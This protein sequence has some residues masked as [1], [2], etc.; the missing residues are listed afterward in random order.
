LLRTLVLTRIASRPCLSVCRYDT[1]SQTW[2]RSPAVGPERRHSAVMMTTGWAHLVVWGG[3]S[4]LYGTVL[5]DVS[6]FDFKAGAWALDMDATRVVPSMINRRPLPRYGHAV[7]RSGNV[8]YE[9][10]GVL[11]GGQHSNKLHI[12]R[13]AA[14]LPGS[15]TPG[16]GSYVWSQV[17]F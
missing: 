10:G 16:A 2:F 1:W 3:V 12:H 5:D 14:A 17:T 8:M 7:A 15:L 11:S 6:A 9:F 4:G 13:T